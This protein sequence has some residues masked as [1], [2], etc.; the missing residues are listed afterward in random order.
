[1]P[2]LNPEGRM[3]CEHVFQKGS[4]KGITCNRIILKSN[5]EHRCCDHTIKQATRKYNRAMDVRSRNS[6]LLQS[7]SVSTPV[8]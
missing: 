5:P 7:N 2:H 4:R 6:N 8:N 3:R 1:M